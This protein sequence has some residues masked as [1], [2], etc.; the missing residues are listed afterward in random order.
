MNF[1]NNLLRDH[2][3]FKPGFSKDFPAVKNTKTRCEICSKLTTKTSERHWR[4]SRIFIV[5]FEHVSHLALCF[6]C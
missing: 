3:H 4:R 6:Y 5:N 1:W 2:E